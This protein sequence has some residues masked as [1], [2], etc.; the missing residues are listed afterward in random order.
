[1]ETLRARFSGAAFSVQSLGDWRAQPRRRGRSRGLGFV[2]ALPAAEL[3][4]FGLVAATRHRTPAPLA[5]ARGVEEQ[6][7][8]RFGF[9][10]PDAFRLRA[11]EQAH[12]VG[13]ERGE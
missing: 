7:R 13:G 3:G 11:A 1:M 9:A 4:H 6:T 10:L 2:R 12:G 8:A 5:A